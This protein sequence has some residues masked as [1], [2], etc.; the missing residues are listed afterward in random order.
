MREDMYDDILEAYFE[1]LTLNCYTDNEIERWNEYTAT[2]IEDP[3]IKYRKDTF[4]H[5]LFELKFIPRNE[6][7]A[8]RA[9][10]GT[11]LSYMF[12]NCQNLNTL[13]LSSFDT[14]TVE[15]MKSMF[16]GCRSLEN[17]IYSNNFTTSNCSV[18]DLMFYICI[19]LSSKIKKDIDPK[20]EYED[21][22]K[23]S[24]KK[25]K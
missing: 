3:L 20:G 17:L 25:G 15:N 12:Y 8:S 10:A 11:D 9:D 16:Y 23:D 19:A 24:S 5:Y 6:Y 2:G 4:Y 21:D 22:K 7:D 14:K 1:F 18:L 13:D